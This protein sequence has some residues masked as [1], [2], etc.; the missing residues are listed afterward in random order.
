MNA[1]QNN[2][3]TGFGKD[4]ECKPSCLII[5]NVDLN[6]PEST[7]M[8]KTL[9]KYS[10]GYQLDLEKVSPDDENDMQVDT[11]ISVNKGPKGKG[12]QGGKPGKKIDRPII[13]IVND[14][15]GPKIQP[16]LQHALAV[17]I[18]GVDPVKMVERL[19]HVVKREKI[20]MDKSTIR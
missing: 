8:I 3:V 11:S 5:D 1:T 10:R 6:Q 16:L 4:K 17:K 19:E 7:L 18:R 9:V 15:Y 12:N 2:H 13:I 20:T 14:I